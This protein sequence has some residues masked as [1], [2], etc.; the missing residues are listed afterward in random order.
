MAKTFLTELPYGIYHNG[1]LHKEVEVLMMTGNIRKEL[2]N[3]KKFKNSAKLETEI[4]KTVVK[5]LGNKSHPT[6]KDFK[7]LCVADRS[8]LMIQLYINSSRDKRTMMDLTVTC[9]NQMCEIVNDFS[10]DL[11]KVEYTPVPEKLEQWKDEDLQYFTLDIFGE[12]FL[13]RFPTGADSETLEPFA[14]DF[15][16]VQQ[17]LLTRCLLSHEGEDDAEKDTV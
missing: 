2:M 16:K 3:L 11:N 6:E 1:E 8:H 17:E 14:K 12:K 4:L 9:V 15:D 7:N 10:V 13:F 5:T